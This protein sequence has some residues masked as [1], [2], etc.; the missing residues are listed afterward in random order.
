M[1]RL[2]FHLRSGYFGKLLLHY[3][4]GCSLFPPRFKWSKITTNKSE[5]SV[6][7]LSRL[8]CLD[9]AESLSNIRVP[10]SKWCHS[11]CFFSWSWSKILYF[12]FEK[13]GKRWYDRIVGETFPFLC[14][15]EICLGEKS[16]DHFGWIVKKVKIKCGVYP[17]RAV[18]KVG[19]VV[20]RHLAGYWCKAGYSLC[21]VWQRAVIVVFGW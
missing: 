12:Y 10:K 19:I 3:N 18:L 17:L 13:G 11:L 1:Y 5:R 15:Y 16:L 14:L 9:S 21:P 20:L 6:N 8:K 2:F 7:Y 4:T